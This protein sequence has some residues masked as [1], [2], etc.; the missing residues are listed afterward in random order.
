MRSIFRITRHILT[1][2]SW[3]ALSLLPSYAQQAIEFSGSEILI[4]D[5]TDYMVENP[6]TENLIIYLTPKEGTQYAEARIVQ[7][8]DTT[9]L[10][11][12]KITFHMQ[13]EHLIME[14]DARI[15]QGENVLTGPQGIEYAAAKNTLVATGT[16]KSLATFKYVKNNG[17]ANDVSAEQLTFRFEER[18][19]ERYVT[20]FQARGNHNT[21]FKFPNE[22]KQQKGQAMVPKLS[23]PK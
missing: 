4:G 7:G 14:G 19:G 18:D 5:N 15:A 17:Q 9:Q 11:A 16:P 23:Q 12:R 22:S 2:A 1:V 8:S 6:L 10:R 13:S 20:N 21:R 3:L